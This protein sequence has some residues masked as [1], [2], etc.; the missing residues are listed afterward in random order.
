MR[1]LVPRDSIAGGDDGDFR[2]ARVT[3]GPAQGSFSTWTRSASV[4]ATSASRE[5]SDALFL[6][7][8]NWDGSPVDPRSETLLEHSS[9]FF[10]LASLCTHLRATH[11]QDLTIEPDV[12]VDQVTD[13][14]ST[15][16]VAT[17]WESLIGALPSVQILRLH[18]GSPSLLSTISNPTLLPNL[19]KI[20]VVQCIVRYT[21]EPSDVLALWNLKRL[22]LRTSPSPGDATCDG[23]SIGGELV[24]LVRS[25]Y[26]LEVI[27]IG[28]KVDSGTL[29]SLRKRAQVDIGDEWVYV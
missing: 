28:C 5:D 7:E 16:M 3:G 2:M 22:P 13:P 1:G 25:R 29:D 26:G 15:V 27:L 4:P 17:H 24:D 23:A 21:A 14:A 18:R 20:Y 8:I 10:H 12:T 11:V 9:P 6:F 19:Q